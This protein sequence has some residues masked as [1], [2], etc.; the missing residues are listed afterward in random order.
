[1]KEL[2]AVALMVEQGS[3]DRAADDCPDN[4]AT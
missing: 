4:S 2:M 1:M 3:R